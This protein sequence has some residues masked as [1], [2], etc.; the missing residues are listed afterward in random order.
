MYRA[1]PI[2]KFFLAVSGL[3]D[4]KTALDAERTRIQGQLRDVERQQLQTSQQLQS[5]HDELSRA[6]NDNNVRLNEERELQARLTTEIE[7]RERA[8][9]EAHQLRKQ[10]C[11]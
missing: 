10:V 6:R 1:V 5:T 2:L 8:Q 4:T 3:E 11:L 7:E 9:Q